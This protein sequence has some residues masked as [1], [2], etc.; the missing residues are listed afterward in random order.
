MTG[1]NYNQLSSAVGKVGRV[2]LKD[3][4]ML[5]NQRVGKILTN[6]KKCNKE[7]L[8]YNISTMGREPCLSSFLL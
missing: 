2:R 3:E 1:S 8:Y 4:P 5:L 7:F 6:E